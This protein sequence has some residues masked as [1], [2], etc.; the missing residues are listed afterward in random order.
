MTTVTPGVATEGTPA[1]HTR[2]RA[3]HA[4]RTWVAAISLVVGVIHLAVV[5]EHL[6][7]WWLFG[8]FFLV[9]GLAQL[10]YAPWVRRT[11][12]W[13]VPMAGIVGNLAVVLIYV[14]SR[15][16]GLPVEPPEDITRHEGTHGIESVGAL[17]L[18]ATAGELAIICLLTTLLPARMRSATVNVLL[19]GGVA[20]WVLRV[21][22]AL[23]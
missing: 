20:L 22:G 1:V 7:E 6:E 18:A 8:T 4:A 16:T 9:L 10:A 19:V 17:D 13:A 21:S 11:T 2:A 14:A 12:T 15:T 23:G 3:E 5:Q